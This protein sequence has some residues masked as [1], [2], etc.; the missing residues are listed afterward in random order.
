MSR[1]TGDRLRSGVRKIKLNYLSGTGVK[2]P[3]CTWKHKN[4]G[5]TVKQMQQNETETKP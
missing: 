1:I 3:G 2:L 5:Y 4:Q